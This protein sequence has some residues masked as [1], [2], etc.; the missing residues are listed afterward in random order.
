MPRNGIAESYGNC[1]CKFLRNCYCFP[2]WLHHLHSYEEY[3]KLMNTLICAFCWKQAVIYVEIYPGFEL[4]G[5]S[6]FI[7]WA[8]VECCQ[9]AREDKPAVRQLCVRFWLY[10]P[11]WCLLSSVCSVLA[12]CWMLPPSESKSHHTPRSKRQLPG[13]MLLK[14]EPPCAAAPA[15]VWSWPRPGVELAPASPAWTYW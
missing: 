6:V 4:L 10:D 9:L 8:L 7:C 11:H 2:Q 14:A 3:L 12:S 5:T 13:P 1:M 15:L